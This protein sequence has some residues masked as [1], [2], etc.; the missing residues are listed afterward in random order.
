MLFNFD[1]VMKVSVESR[2]SFRGSYL[3]CGAMGATHLAELVLFEKWKLEKGSWPT[4]Q[5]SG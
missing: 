3:M 4:S 5:L 2:M 1:L